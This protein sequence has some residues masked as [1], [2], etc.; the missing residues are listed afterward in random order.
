MLTYL[1]SSVQEVS[2]LYITIKTT[3]TF[4]R[5]HLVYTEI[6]SESHINLDLISS[7]IVDTDTGAKV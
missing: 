6:Y 1:T 5:V 3:I 2:W 7:R 4:T